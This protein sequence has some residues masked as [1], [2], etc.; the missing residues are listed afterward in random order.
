[1]VV[2]EQER[3]LHGGIDENITWIYKILKTGTLANV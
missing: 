1:M 2:G 3:T